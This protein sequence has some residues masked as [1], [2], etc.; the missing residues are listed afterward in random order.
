M[1]ASM[2]GPDF[3]Q[4]HGFFEAA[5]NFYM[6]F[7]PQA[8]EAAHGDPKVL[9]VIQAVEDD[10]PNLWKKGLSPEERKKID[11]FYKER[12]GEKGEK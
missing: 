12:Y 3:V 9:A 2:Q 11:E 5:E 10:R 4:W 8:R 6:T 7:L 1:G